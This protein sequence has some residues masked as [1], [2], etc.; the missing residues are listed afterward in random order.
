VATFNAEALLPL[1]LL[2]VRHEDVPNGN[3]THEG[4]FRRPGNPRSRN[5]AANS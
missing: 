5:A 3:A 4:L 2:C 1:G